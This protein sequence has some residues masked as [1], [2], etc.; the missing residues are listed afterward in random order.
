MIRKLLIPSLI[1]GGMVGSGFL[2]EAQA[3][4]RRVEIG[5]ALEALDVKKPTEGRKLLV[6]SLTRGFKHASIRTGQ[7]MME[8]MAEKT[9]AFEVVVSNDLSN[10]EPDAIKQFDAICFLNTTMEVFSPAKGALA[11][12]NDDEKKKSAETE[13]RL[14]KSLM[15]FIKSG[16]GFI[17]IH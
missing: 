3:G 5:K 10:F 2:E 12:M 9:K 16:K 15:D 6:F 14:K 17:G 4:D 11:K 7:L 13:V 1:C 8:L